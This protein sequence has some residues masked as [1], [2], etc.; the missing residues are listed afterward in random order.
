MKKSMATDSAAAKLFGM[1][2]NVFKDEENAKGSIHLI[3][4]LHECGTFLA[5]ASIKIVTA[6]GM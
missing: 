6:G 2:L 5:M 1:V 4:F 3:K